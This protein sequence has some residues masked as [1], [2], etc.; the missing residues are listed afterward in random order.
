MQ[1]SRERMG[2]SSSIPLVAE[3]CHYIVSKV[4]RMACT[5]LACTFMNEYSQQYQ[6]N[7]ILAGNKPEVI[8]LVL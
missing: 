3:T 5:R 2:N 6:N 1:S 4:G 7:K 8:G